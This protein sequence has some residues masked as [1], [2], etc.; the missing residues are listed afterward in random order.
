MG[1]NV[2][3]NTRAGLGWVI[4]AWRLSVGQ[5]S[6]LGRCPCSGRGATCAASRCP[7]WQLFFFFLSLFRAYVSMRCT[8]G[9]QYPRMG[10]G[11]PRI[12]TEVFCA[13]MVGLG[14]GM[15]RRCQ[16]P[17]GFSR[18]IF[19]SEHAARGVWVHSVEKL[20]TDEGWHKTKF[21][22]CTGAVV[23]NGSGFVRWQGK[24]AT[25]PSSCVPF[26]F[27]GILV[28]SFALHWLSVMYIPF[29][30]RLLPSFV[31]C[32]MYVART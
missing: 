5:D 18:S 8:S 31:L 9:A 22:V 23:S 6:T 17:A 2:F 26:F 25:F 30:L 1:V 12:R 24:P 13:S 4:L 28:R 16:R 15:A 10:V 19:I 29:Y 21:S 11:T 3:S 7:S 27:F 32:V 20:L 14:A